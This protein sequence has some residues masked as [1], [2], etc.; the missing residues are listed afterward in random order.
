[1]R[2]IYRIS[3]KICVKLDDDQVYSCQNFLS[4]MI[5]AILIWKALTAKVKKFSQWN[6]YKACQSDSAQT[7]AVMACCFKCAACG[8]I[9]IILEII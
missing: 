4:M 8:E 5:T 9:P 6:R 3:R 1:M 7:E 2:K